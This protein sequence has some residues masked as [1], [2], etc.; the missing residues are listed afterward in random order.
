ME[1]IKEALEKAREQREQEF[2][3][4]RGSVTNKRSSGST[5]GASRILEREPFRGYSAVQQKSLI[6]SSRVINVTIGDTLQFAGDK[7]DYVR[8][9]LAG[10]VVLEDAA[11]RTTTITAGQD[12]AHQ[13]LD[14]P[15]LKQHTIVATLDAEILRVPEAA[16][17]R[18]SE[19]D[20]SPIPKAVDTETFSGQ[21]LA[22]LVDQINDDL[23]GE[24][25]AIRQVDP[26]VLICDDNLE[27]SLSDLSTSAERLLADIAIDATPDDPENANATYVPQYDDELG[28][29]TRELELRF[30]R[31]VER[32]KIAE[33]TRYEEQL[34]D[35]AAN[36]KEMA[37]VQSCAALNKQSKRP[38]E[39][40][41]KQDRQLRERYNALKNFANRI[42]RQK[43]AIYAARRKISARLGL[44]ERIH[45][46]LA[47]LGTQLDAQLDDLDEQMSEAGKG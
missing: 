26:S 46:E 4:D 16:L 37:Q 32:V 40:Y 36:L 30:R 19:Q 38:R 47:Q 18:S 6:E 43:A 14:N 34:Q 27:D 1:R 42:A 23:Q 3:F 10:A 7:G 28:K 17:P 31:Y 9:L 13:P 15:G 29:F 20:A 21:Q 11:S 33:R 2:T 25:N 39:A 41:A 45:R 22:E 24:R 44:A 5:L 35:H 8:Y 12:A